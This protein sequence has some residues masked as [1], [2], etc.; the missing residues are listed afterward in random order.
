MTIITLPINPD[1][2]YG[3]SLSVENISVGDT[4]FIGSNFNAVSTLVKEIIKESIGYTII[5]DN[6]KLFALFNTRVNVKAF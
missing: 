1:N 6:F 4:L 3:M 2:Y 5:T